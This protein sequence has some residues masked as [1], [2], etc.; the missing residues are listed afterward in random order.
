MLYSFAAPFVE[1]VAYVDD[2]I[3]DSGV[4]VDG[5]P[6]VSFATWHARYRRFPVFVTLGDPVARRRIVERLSE[7]GAFFSDFSDRTSSL[8]RSG[9]MGRGTFLAHL[10]SIGPNVTF[11][12][13]THVLP[14]A[15]IGTAT[16]FGD[17]TMIAQSVTIGPGVVIEDEAWVG[18]GATIVA[19]P[20]GETLHIGRGARVSAGAVVTRSVAPGHRV[21]GN[22]AVDARS[23]VVARRASG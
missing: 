11:G 15:S 19:E 4:E 12:A 18:I 5:E 16:R 6:V 9:T 3:G 7:A 13:H 2:F 17:F 23:A 8:P 1:P 22:P 20:S 10:T 14:F 21:Y